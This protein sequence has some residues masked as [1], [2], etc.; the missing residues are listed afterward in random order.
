MKAIYKR[1]LRSYFNSMTGYL[2]I[3]VVIAF[4][5][6]YFMAVNLF[7][8]YPRFSEALSSTLSVFMFAI[9]VLTMR[10]LADER[11]SRTDQLLLTAPVSLTRVVLGK[12]LAMVTVLAIPTL[13]F[14]TCP[15]IIMANGTGYPLSDYASLLAF[16]LIGCAFIAIGMFISSLTESQVISSVCTF[17]VLFAIYLWPS[18][19]DYLPDSAF[20]SMVGFLGLTVVLCAILW[21]MTHNALLTAGLGVIGVGTVFALYFLNSDALAGTFPAMLGVFSLRDPFSN[22]TRYSMFDVGGI[23]LYLSFIFVF[24]FLTVQTLQKRR[25]S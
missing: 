13:L 5:G 17:G 1:E 25:W 10:S 16:F 4:T 23:V 22:F 19:V 2:F 11:R 14:C 6:V 24:V 8:G 12:Y 18:L 7:G 20:A 21:N 9:P 3:A 15:L